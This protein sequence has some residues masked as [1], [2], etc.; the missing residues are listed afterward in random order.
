MKTF[1]S[2]SKI[3]DVRKVSFK[4]KWPFFSFYPSFLSYF[5]LSFFYP[6]RL[7]LLALFVFF[8]TLLF[9]ESLV[10]NKV[11]LA[12]MWLFKLVFFEFKLVNYKDFYW[13]LKF[14]FYLMFLD[15]PGLRFQMFSNYFI[16][17]FCIFLFEGLL[18]CEGIRLAMWCV[19]GGL[20]INIFH[21]YVF[22][23]DVWEVRFFEWFFVLKRF[24]VS[25]LFWGEV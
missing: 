18:F 17:I 11:Y 21:V 1:P 10:K 25:F 16:L 9:P 7:L 20:R 13:I 24:S 3:I 5:T 8:F 14:L 23:V 6:F 19:W 12:L 4:Y 22:R 15:C 2:W